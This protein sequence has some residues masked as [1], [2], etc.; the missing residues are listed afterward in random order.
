[1]PLP[2]DAI[3]H[4]YGIGVMQRIPRGAKALATPYLHEIQE[5]PDAE[6]AVILATVKCVAH[7]DAVEG[8]EQEAP[9][10]V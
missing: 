5:S 2:T 3:D 10:G 7:A 4:G 9:A 6:Y 8:S 1:M